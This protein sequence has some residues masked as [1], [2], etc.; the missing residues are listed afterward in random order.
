MFNDI[1]PRLGIVISTFRKF[2]NTIRSTHTF[3]R[4][5]IKALHK[6]GK[7]L[8][9]ETDNLV[10]KKIYIILF[11]IRKIVDFMHLFNFYNTSIVVKFD[12]KNYPA[13]KL[14]FYSN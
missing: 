1:K 2:T 6:N 11:G 7:L 3:L 10:V 5:L 8:N 12:L 9:L 14:N 4:T 13:T